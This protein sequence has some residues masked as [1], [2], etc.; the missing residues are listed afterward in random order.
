MAAG[1]FSAKDVSHIMK[2]KGDQFSFYKFQL[3]LVLKNYALLGIVEGVETKPTAVA[4]LADHSNNAAVTTR[5]SEIDDWEK[6][7]TAAQNYIVATL[8]EKVMMTIMNC[9]TANSM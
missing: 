4:L 2:F 7:D 9:K 1:T 6:K 3:K 8:E 5:N